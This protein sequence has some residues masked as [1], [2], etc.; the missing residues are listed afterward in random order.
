MGSGQVALGWVCNEM[1]QINQLRLDDLK[2]Q[3]TKSSALP[4]TLSPARQ[5]GKLQFSAGPKAL[6]SISEA[7]KTPGVLGDSFRDKTMQPQREG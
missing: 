6:G 1:A 3:A 2:T 7:K 5:R 4:D